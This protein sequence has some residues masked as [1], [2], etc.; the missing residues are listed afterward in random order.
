MF[1]TVGLKKKKLSKHFNNKRFHM[2]MPISDASRK[3][4]IWLPSAGAERES[5]SCGGHSVLI[6]SLP[7]D[8]LVFEFEA[9]VY[10][11]KVWMFNAQRGTFVTSCCG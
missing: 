5:A 9:L 6:L 2:K 11:E 4:R 8:I 3:I 1:C 10:R 7:G